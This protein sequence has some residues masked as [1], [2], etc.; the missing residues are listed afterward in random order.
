MSGPK[1]RAAGT[2]VV[3]PGF[4]A[5]RDALLRHGRQADVREALA[6]IGFANG[7]ELRPIETARNAMGSVALSATQAKRPA[8]LEDRKYVYPA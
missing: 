2:H 3:R 6:V 5:V 4:R 1:L 7:L 8:H